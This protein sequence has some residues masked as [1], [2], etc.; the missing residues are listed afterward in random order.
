MLA[1][2][3]KTVVRPDG[4]IELRSTEFPSGTPV[5]VIVLA[6]DIPTRAEEAPMEG[7]PMSAMIGSAKGLF[8]SVQEVDEYLQRE[9]DSWDS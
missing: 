9:R 3:K 7:Q 4:V 6:A 5:E 8:R 2:R 1:I